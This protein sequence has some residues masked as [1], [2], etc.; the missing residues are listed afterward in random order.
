VTAQFTVEERNLLV[1]LPRWIVGAASAAHT[2]TAGKTQQEINTGL[3]SVA[4]G[5]KLGNALVAELAD[6][7]IRV[8]DD[9][10]KQSNID[11]ST[12]A[13]RDQI[14]SY[15]QL[16]VNILRQKAEAADATTYRRWLIEIT[17][18]V[19]SAVDSDRRFGFGGTLVHADEQ[20][21][22]DRLR[23]VTRAPSA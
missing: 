2:D 15:A 6:A 9:D 5:R 17:D 7:A 20:A 4:N 10:L 13:G 3:V 8:Y 21:F 16:A 1:R 18:D 19:I 23:D 12:P 11:P 14:L 22:R